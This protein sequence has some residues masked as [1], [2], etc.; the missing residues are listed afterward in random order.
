M[1]TRS[2]QPTIDR[3]AVLWDLLSLCH[4]RLNKIIIERFSVIDNVPECLL[5]ARVVLGMQTGAL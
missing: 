4:F 5:D 2:P 3:K 1:V